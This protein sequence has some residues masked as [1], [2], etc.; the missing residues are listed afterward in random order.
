MAFQEHRGN[1]TA[2]TLG[3]CFGRSATRGSSQ[4][5][6]RR[7]RA[8]RRRRLGA[9]WT[10]LRRQQIAC[11]A[12]SCAPEAWNPATGPPTPP[13]PTSCLSSGTGW[14]R[15]SLPGGRWT[16]TTARSPTGHG[17]SPSLCKRSYHSRGGGRSSTMLPTSA[18]SCT[19]STFQVRASCSWQRRTRH[20]TTCNCRCRAAAWPGTTWCFAMAACHPPAASFPREFTAWK[21][22]LA[23]FRAWAGPHAHVRR[24]WPTL[25]QTW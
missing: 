3:G 9:P 5:S 14:S 1:S 12:L 13:T 16:S 25:R 20:T 24:P 15:T 22:C 2:N 18:V 10:A 6:C 17:L 8:R 4:T 7:W 21:A 23:W 11:K 19:G